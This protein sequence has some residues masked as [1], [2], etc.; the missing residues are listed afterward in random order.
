M[1][2]QICDCMCISRLIENLEHNNE[3]CNDNDEHDGENDD[4]DGVQ[5]V[6]FI[7]ICDVVE[8]GQF[9]ACVLVLQVKF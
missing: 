8:P 6:Q 3:G 5:N 1:K 4:V 9:T 7:M 2:Q